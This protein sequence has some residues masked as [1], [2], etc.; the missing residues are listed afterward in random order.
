MEELA[1]LNEPHAQEGEERK[2]WNLSTREGFAAFYDYWAPRI[3]RHALIR[4]SSPEVAQDIASK[5]FLNVLEYV[6]AQKRI[7]RAPS[8]LYKVVNHL[9]IDHYRSRSSHTIPLSTLAPYDDPQSDDS[10]ERE[11]GTHYNAALVRYA[12]GTLKPQESALL[13]MRY[14]DDLSIEEIALVF[15]KSR[16]AISVAIHRA[17]R[18]LHDVIEKDHGRLV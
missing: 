8:F 16:G 14:V 2:D 18:E 7:H 6:K 9:V 10:P 4:T 12:I 17:L 13:T 11:A 5:A 15:G 3:Y 1:R